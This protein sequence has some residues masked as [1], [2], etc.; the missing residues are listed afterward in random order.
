MTADALK[1]EALF[2]AE[3]PPTPAP[4][5]PGAPSALRRAR[6]AV[7]PA[8]RTFIARLDETSA[9][10]ASYHLGWTDVGGA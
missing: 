10:I 7:V 5:R 6:D 1:T 2:T 8:T 3:V 4:V 9:A